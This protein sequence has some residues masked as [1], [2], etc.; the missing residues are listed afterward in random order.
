MEEEFNNPQYIQSSLNRPGETTQA[1]MVVID[2]NTGFVVGCVGGLGEKTVSRGLNRATQSTR[3]TGSSMKPIAVVAPA[4]QERKITA[5]SIYGDVRTTFTLKTGELYNPKN[6]NY[7][8][9]NITVRQALETSQNI[10][11]IKTKI[12]KNFFFINL[13]PFFVQ[14]FA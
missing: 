10:P 11:F 1:A 3:Q 7:Y 2:H 12:I 9:G 14:V 13:A 6:Y 4:M 5:A 8:R